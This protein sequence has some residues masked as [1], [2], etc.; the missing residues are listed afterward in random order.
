MGVQVS[1][2]IRAT[3]LIASALLLGACS[4]AKK[5]PP[6]LR[7]TN[8][9]DQAIE[10]ALRAKAAG[11]RGDV[12]EAINLY[13]EAV[14]T[15]ARLTAAWNNLGILYMEQS[16]YFEAAD[17]FRVAADTAQQDPTPLENLALSYHRAGYD[18]QALRYY[19]LALDRSP[20]RISA[21]RGVV[22]VA[23][24]M[25]RADETILEYVNRALMLEPH[26][27]WRQVFERERVR[28][29]G[30]IRTRESIEIGN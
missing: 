6:E 11:D 5:A 23:N 8:D 1:A 14:R 7:M 30:Q 13:E 9:R 16:N 2:H 17:R 29:E 4:G 19:Q 27:E 24:R 10:I 3:V 25:H 22:R 26:P 21:L 20:N 15:D 28:I 12:D 18:D